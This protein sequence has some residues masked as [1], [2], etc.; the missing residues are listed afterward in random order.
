MADTE[1]APADAPAP[2][3]APEPEVV[4]NATAPAADPLPSIRVESEPAAPRAESVKIKVS[5]SPKPAPRAASPPPEKY[6]VTSPL[7]ETYKPRSSSV[8]RGTDFDLYGSKL[9]SSKYDN[10]DTGIDRDYTHRLYDIAGVSSVRDNIMS[11]P[12]LMRNR[13]ESS[14]STP[15]HSSRSRYVMRMGYDLGFT[16]PSLRRLYDVC[17]TNHINFHIKPF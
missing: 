4:E 10:D 14:S 3:P 13:P 1:T 16:S 12:L 6:R 7:R 15:I 5:D 11:H 17:I 2:V 9:Y 8:D